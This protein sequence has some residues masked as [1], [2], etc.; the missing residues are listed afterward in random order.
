MEKNSLYE[1]SAMND[2]TQHVLY[3]CSDAA[4]HL[5]QLRGEALVEDA[6]DSC[7]S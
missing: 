4:T 2:V 6:I 3:E 7:P 5:D 1:D